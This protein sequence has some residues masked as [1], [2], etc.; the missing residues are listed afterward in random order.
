MSVGKFNLQYCIIFLKRVVLSLAVSCIHLASTCPCNHLFLLYNNFS[1]SFPSTAHVRNA[2]IVIKTQLSAP[3]LNTRHLV[4]VSLMFYE[5]SF[6]NYY[7]D[8]IYTALRKLG[9][10]PY[11]MHEII[12]RTVCMRKYNKKKRMLTEGIMFKDHFISTSSP[13]KVIAN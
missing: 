1:F 7:R 3:P 4:N 11:K 13:I 2:V 9:K 10:I 8:W 5:G 12:L 6:I